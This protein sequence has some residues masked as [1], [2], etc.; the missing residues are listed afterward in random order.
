MLDAKIYTYAYYIIDNDYFYQYLPSGNIND[1]IY[2]NGMKFVE[3]KSFIKDGDCYIKIP[4][5]SKKIGVGT[6]I[7]SS[8]II[9]RYYAGDPIFQ[10]YEKELIE[11]LSSTNNH[12]WTLYGDGEVTLEHYQNYI[13]INRGI[14]PEAESPKNIVMGEAHWYL[15][16]KLED[17]S[18]KYEETICDDKK[19]RG[20]KC[21]DYSFVRVLEYDLNGEKKKTVIERSESHPYHY[22]EVTWL[23]STVDQAKK[24]I[25]KENSFSGFAGVSPLYTFNTEDSACVFYDNQEKIKNS[26]VLT[27]TGSG[28][29]ILDLFLYGAEKVIAFDTNI[30]TIFF[31]ELKFIAAKYLSFDEFKMF[32]S[33]FDEKIY[34]RIESNLSNNCRMFWNELYR[35][36]KVVDKPIKNNENGGLFYPTMSLFTA[37]DTIGNKKG[38][39]TEEQYLKLQRI[40]DDKSLDDVSL[41][42]CDLFDLP[43]KVNLKDVSYA[44]LSNIMDF[45]VGVDKMKLDTSSLK[46]FKDYILNI[47]LPVLKENADVDLSYLKSNWHMPNDIDTYLSIYSLDEGFSIRP[48]SNRRDSILEYESSVLEKNVDNKKY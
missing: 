23:D 16:L 21:K 20:Q 22:V 35:F 44:Y 30:L 42:N 43:N 45:L 25:I 8:E 6:P 19:Y 11:Y 14:M 24:L 34:R 10:K 7:Y 9:E 1:T 17:G 28:D 40:L 5:N 26:I 18:I 33:N 38:Y 2:V 36:C 32:F 39:Y 15:E 31:A 48:L 3:E 41:I 47:L 13:G 29:A 27:V 12:Q 37:N 46:D 4:N